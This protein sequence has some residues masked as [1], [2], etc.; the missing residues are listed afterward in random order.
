MVDTAM[1]HYRLFLDPHCEDGE[2]L[3][4]PRHKGEKFGD[5]TRFVRPGPLVLDRPFVIQINNPGDPVDMYMPMNIWIATPAIGAL[6][7]QVAGHAEVQ[8]IPCTTEDGRP[9]EVLHT[10]LHLDC[11]DLDRCKGVTYKDEKEIRMQEKYGVVKPR[12]PFIKHI[13]EITLDPDKTQ[14]LH[15]FRIADYSIV[16]LI[17]EDLKLALQ[18]RGATGV[19]F[20]PLP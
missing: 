18:S 4:V 1:S 11:L 10:L 2:H 6:I 20:L 7:E 13:R 3:D 15:F 8:R 5:H 14:G 16:T 12:P 9:M 17:S 19:S